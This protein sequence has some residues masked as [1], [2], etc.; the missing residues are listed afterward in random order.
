VW[1]RDCPKF[2]GEC[3][4]QTTVRGERQES[5][6]VHG[7]NPW[8][9][10][11][12]VRWLLQCYLEWKLSHLTVWEEIT[13]CFWRSYWEASKRPLKRLAIW[14]LL[15]VLLPLSEKV[16][17]LHGLC[18]V[19]QKMWSESSKCKK[20]QNKKQINPFCGVQVLSVC[21]GTATMSTRH[22]LPTLLLP[23]Q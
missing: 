1:W 15:F 7:N 6:G 18:A 22:H 3:L 2:E 5:E 13:H 12:H 10:S 20:K 19:Q 16:L 8:L 14:L 4:W 23:H 11:P 21:V 9:W 17:W